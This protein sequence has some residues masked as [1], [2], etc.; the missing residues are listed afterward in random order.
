MF[1]ADLDAPELSGPDRHHLQRVLRLAPDARVTAAD[2]AGGW[3]VCRVGG[4]E[5]GAAGNRLD[6]ETEVTVEPRPRPA[7]G[8]AFALT[9]GERPEWT[10]QK[11]TELGVDSIVPVVAARSVVRLERERADRRIERWRRVAREASAQCRRA[12][13]PEVDDIRT[14]A[15]VAD[16]P[17]A[18]L[19][20]PGGG[21]PTLATPLVLVGPEGG[22][23]PA[24]LE[25]AATLPRVGLGPLV[26]R[27]ETAA[28]AT[29][30]LLGG[31]RAGVVGPAATPGS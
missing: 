23:D 21:P 17:G 22:W 8:V 6:P 12:W 3:R 11:L 2:G 9:K 4:W 15:E 13:L 28:V 27:A 29:A 31:L 25:R 20:E 1:V 7:I 14:F 5:T 10:V 18:A 16:R 26:L 19:A 30:A 24:E